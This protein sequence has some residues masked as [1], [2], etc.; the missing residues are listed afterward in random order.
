LHLTGTTYLSYLPIVSIRNISMVSLLATDYIKELAP[1]GPEANESLAPSETAPA[2]VGGAP[3][4]LDLR[5][6][7]R[8]CAV[9]VGA[10]KPQPSASISR[11]HHGGRPPVDTDCSVGGSTLQRLSVYLE[12]EK[13]IGKPPTF[14]KSFYFI[15]TASCMP[16]D[17][18]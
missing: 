17:S 3:L 10:P 14:W 7:E 13:E 1:I 4:S 18:Q 8:K 11:A 5:K 6:T 9:D 2:N 15:L 12:P 16:H